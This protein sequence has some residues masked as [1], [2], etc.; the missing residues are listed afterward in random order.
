MIQIGNHKIN[1]N[2]ETQASKNGRPFRLSGVSSVTTKPAQ[3]IDKK[4]VHG[5]IYSFRYLDVD[6]EFFGFE[7]TP[8]GKFL[9][10]IIIN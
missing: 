8:D 3:W 7:F 2:F 1:L 6:N 10:K 4:L 5:T 9:S